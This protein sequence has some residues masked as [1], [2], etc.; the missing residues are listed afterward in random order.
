MAIPSCQIDS[1]GALARWLLAW[2]ADA[3]VEER[4]AMV[5]ATYGLWLARNEARDGRAIA[6]PHEIMDTVVSYMNEWTTVHTKE[7]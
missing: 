6:A 5:Q 7:R 4:A 3:G 1:Q 2:F